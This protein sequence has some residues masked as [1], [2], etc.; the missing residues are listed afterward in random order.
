MNPH[1]KVLEVHLN[2]LLSQG[3]GHRQQGQAAGD[4]RRTGPLLR[5]APGHPLPPGPP[6][7]EPGRHAEG[8]VRG[9]HQSGSA[10][11]STAAQG[12]MPRQLCMRGEQDASPHSIFN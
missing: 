11:R 2:V 1:G 6:L 5:G 3:V 8:G 10:H 9:G 12:Q 4:V 7:S